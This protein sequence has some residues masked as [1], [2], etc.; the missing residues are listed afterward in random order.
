MYVVQ[1]TEQIQTSDTGSRVITYQWHHFSKNINAFLKLCQVIHFPC[2]ARLCTS[3]RN[4][5]S[6]MNYIICIMHY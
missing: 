1:T 5:I 2:H 4:C 6:L 3:G